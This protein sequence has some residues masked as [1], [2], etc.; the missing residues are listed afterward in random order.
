MTT[1]ELAIE[2]LVKEIAIRQNAVKA[3]QEVAQ[4]SLRA[5]DLLVRPDGEN[6]GYRLTEKGA[7]HLREQKQRVHEVKLGRAAKP[8]AGGERAGS[9]GARVREAC[10]A[11]TAPFDQADVAREMGKGTTTGQ[12]RGVLSYLAKTGR[13]KIVTPGRPGHPGKYALAGG[14]PPTPKTENGSA[15]KR[16]TVPGLDADEASL[17]SKLETALKERDQAVSAG[18]ETLGRILQDKVNDLQRRLGLVQT[19]GRKG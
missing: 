19:S 4:P 2:Q 8:K 3:L 7:K 5:G 10:E 9:L 18:Q 15:P 17:E 14:R 6:P 1:L 16:V 11:C 13:L 12:V